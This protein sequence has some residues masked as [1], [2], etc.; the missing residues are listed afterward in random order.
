VAKWGQFMLE[1]G[2][3]F[4]RIFHYAMVARVSAMVKKKRAAV[5]LLSPVW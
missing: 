3:Q 2:G 5:M 1:L 4:K